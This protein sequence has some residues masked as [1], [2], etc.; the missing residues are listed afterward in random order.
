LFT[1]SQRRQVR[2]LLRCWPLLEL[3]TRPSAANSTC[4]TAFSCPLKLCNSLPAARFHRRTVLSLPPETALVL[5]G[6][7]ATLCTAPAWP[8]RRTICFFC[9]AF[10]NRTVA[11]RLPLNIPCLVQTRLVTTSLCPTRAAISLPE[12]MSQMRKLR[13]SPPETAFLPSGENASV[14]T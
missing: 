13:S 12:P 4:T 10:Q 3:T 9:A 6:D 2:S 14:R 1:R 7:K 5:S 11:S 8:S